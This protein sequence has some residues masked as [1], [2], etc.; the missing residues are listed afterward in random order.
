MDEK[1]I[2]ISIDDEIVDSFTKVFSSI[3]MV[4]YLVQNRLVLVGEPLEFCGFIQL[5]CTWR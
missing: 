5:N 2:I 4:N 1:L 3:A